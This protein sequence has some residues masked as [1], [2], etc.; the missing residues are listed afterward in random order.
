MKKLTFLL[1][2]CCVTALTGCT[3]KAPNCSDEQTLDIVRS[4]ILEHSVPEDVRAQ[5]EL[6]TVQAAIQFNAARPLS[7]DKDANIYHCNAQMILNNEI[8]YDLNY[9]SQRLDNGDSYS[10]ITTP[11]RGGD[12]YQIGMALNNAFQPIISEQGATKA[13]GAE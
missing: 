10:A 1:T 12:W 3:E 7:Y 9:D 6:N 13:D 8:Q 2:L 5:L 4:I 11:L